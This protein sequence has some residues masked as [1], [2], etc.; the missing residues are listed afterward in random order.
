MEQFNRG[1]RANCSDPA[2]SPFVPL[3]IRAPFRPQ[4]RR[5]G[6]AVS[7][8]PNAYTRSISVR[9]F[10]CCVC[11]CFFSEA[12]SECA[13]ALKPGEILAPELGAE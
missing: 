10:I 9:G 6:A 5:E 12:N 8:A 13:L 2:V 7:S 3:L 4:P 11:V 1:E